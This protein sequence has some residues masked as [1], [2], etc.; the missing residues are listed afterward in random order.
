MPDITENVQFTHVARE[1]RAKFKADDDKRSLVK[2]QAVLDKLLTEL[3]AVTGVTRIQRIVCGQC[4]DFKVITTLEEEAFGAWAEGGFAPEKEFL[5][6][7]EAA[8]CGAIETQTFTIEDVAG[9]PSDP[10]DLEQDFTPNGEVK[11][12][13]L[14]HEWRG[15]WSEDNNKESLVKAQEV[16]ENALDRMSGIQGVDRVQRVV[17]GSCHDFKV[18][19][20]VR[21]AD[22]LAAW[23]KGT[24]FAPE[25]DV[26]KE[27]EAA[28]LAEIATQTYTIRDL[29]AKL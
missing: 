14:A 7:L 25:A 15:K 23:A 28:G 27:L 24:N 3:Q 8:G 18:I 9:T 2:A 16:L 21:D 5:A 22:A 10:S 19:V 12:T 26:L 6:G 1:W 17:C 29:H 20:T 13:Q 11:F 4:N